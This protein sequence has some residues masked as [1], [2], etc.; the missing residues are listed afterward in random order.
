[1]LAEE[2]ARI[3]LEG[4]ATCDEEQAPNVRSIA[5]TVRASGSR[6]MAINLARAEPHVPATRLV[7]G[8]LKAVF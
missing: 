8:T 2:L 7:A 1:M 4:F 3:R 5:K 6:L